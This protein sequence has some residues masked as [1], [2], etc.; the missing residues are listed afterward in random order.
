MSVRPVG[1]KP[2]NV[3]DSAGGMVVVVSLSRVQY[4]PGKFNTFNIQ[5]Q[6]PSTE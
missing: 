1:A 2:S 6:V 5:Y 3:S 4:I